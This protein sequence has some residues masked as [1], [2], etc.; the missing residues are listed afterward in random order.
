MNRPQPGLLTSY[1]AVRKDKLTVE[2]FAN[3][4]D[5]WDHFI[6][7]GAFSAASLGVSIDIEDYIAFAR[8]VAPYVS[9]IATFDV[10]GDHEATARNTERMMEFDDLR[11]KLMPVFHLGSPP[12]AMTRAMIQARE[13]FGR[14]A[15]G[16][17]VPLV[18]NEPEL[19][20][21]SAY[22]H[23]R[24]KEFGGIKLHAFGVVYP[25]IFLRY[26]W[27]SA[28]S[29]TWLTPRRHGKIH[30]IINN[31]WRSL[32]IAAAAHKHPLLCSRLGVPSTAIAGLYGPRAKWNFWPGTFMQL[33]ALA[34]MEDMAA[35]P[36]GSHGVI[37]SAAGENALGHQ[38][39]NRARMR[40]MFS[41]AYAREDFPAEGWDW[42]VTTG[43]RAS[44][45]KQAA[46]PA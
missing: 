24:A 28:D 35:R 45:K 29:T 15:I 10:I 9:R 11:P 19:H 34:E 7:S 30:A 38:E 33:R 32:S 31:R 3:S 5:I 25:G 23:H 6:D 20:R 2:M 44:A 13:C 22:V 17:M 37:Y 12:A 43:P 4:V 39:I 40:V 42:I 46:A 8:D 21:G 16:R 18:K 41:A 26:P 1:H 27:E 36:D 14:L